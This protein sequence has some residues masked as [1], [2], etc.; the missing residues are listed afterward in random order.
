MCIYVYTYIYIYMIYGDTHTH[1]YIYIYVLMIKA[2]SRNRVCSQGFGL[3]VMLCVMS[4]SPMI[5]THI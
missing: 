3:V 4:H 5:K 2:L 1:M